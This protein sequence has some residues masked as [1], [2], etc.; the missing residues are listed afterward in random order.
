MDIRLTLRKGPLEVEIEASDD[1]DYQAEILE[2]LEFLDSNEDQL[3]ELDAPNEEPDPE[4][5]QA[6]VTDWSN[7]TESASTE[8]Q[9]TSDVEAGPDVVENGPAAEFASQLRVNPDR[10]VEVIDIDPN[11]EEEPFID[12]DT[13]EFGETRIERQFHGALILLGTWQECYGV[14]RIASSDLKDALDISGID[15]DSLYNMYQRIDEVDSYLD[16][17][18]R[19]S[20]ATVALTRPGLREAQNR[21]REL[22]EE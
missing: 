15:S 3:R 6:S 8:E 13:A 4:P 20:S 17:S 12:A 21:I 22:V 16:T 10:L 7:Q 9:D 14:D 11:L 5:E 19:G 18:G 2:I 1:D